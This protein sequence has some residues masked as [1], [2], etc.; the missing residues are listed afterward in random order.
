MD[1]QASIE[2]RQVATGSL[3]SAQLEY[4]ENAQVSPGPWFSGEK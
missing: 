1:L 3:D 4:L 2:G